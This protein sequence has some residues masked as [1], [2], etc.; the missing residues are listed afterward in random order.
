VARILRLLGRLSARVGAMMELWVGGRPAN[1]AP[2][3]ADALADECRL[4][5]TTDGE[6]RHADERFKR[7]WATYYGPVPET[8]GE[9]LAALQR[10]APGTATARHL[11]P[12]N[13]ALAGL[14]ASEVLAMRTAT[15]SRRIHLRAAPVVDRGGR[16]QGAVAVWRDL[17][18]S[19]VSA[20]W[21]RL[22]RPST[23][24]SAN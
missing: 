2:L 5:F 22:E 21:A 13:L 17:G 11:L 10:T 12:V 1:D 8:A 6:L 7:W 20:A 16:V 4:I 15:G 14:P 23:G 18:L 19:V 9:L 24:A 3:L